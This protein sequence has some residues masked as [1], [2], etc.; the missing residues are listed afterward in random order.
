M[1]R[2][3]L[4]IIL[5]A[6][7]AGCEDT[8]EFA[9]VE[10]SLGAY[11]SFS[12]NSAAF[13]ENSAT[14]SADGTSVVAGNSYAVEIFRSTSDLS[15]PLTVS[16][17]ADVVF[18]STTDFANAGDDASSTVAFST[19]VSSLTFEAGEAFK[20]F[21]ITSF[22]D[23]F[24]SGDKSITLSITNA[25]GLNV[26]SQGLGGSIALTVVDDDCPID[27]ASFEGEYTMTVFGTVGAPFDGFD[28]CASAAR[29][30]SGVVTLAADATDPLGQTAI[31]THPSFGGEYKI[32]FI[33]C[34]EEV[35][36]VQPMTSFFGVGAWQMQQGGSLGAYSNDSK[37]ITI[38]GILGTNG[39]FTITL[40]KV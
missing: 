5:A 29:D 20:Q 7:F 18:A 32:Q 19:D 9:K 23:D 31:L 22:N 4:L 34:P 15:S 27:L 2:I 35:E 13:S 11:V 8:S 26:G 10:D 1:K 25:G 33:T 16:I 3:Y 14:T 12:E 38:I 6:F 36:V 21:T 17:S 37:D 28:L 24:S 40:K 30:C 39:D